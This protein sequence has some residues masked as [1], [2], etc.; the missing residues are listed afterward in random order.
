MIENEIPMKNARKQRITVY[1]YS[2]RYIKT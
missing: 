2:T 1:R